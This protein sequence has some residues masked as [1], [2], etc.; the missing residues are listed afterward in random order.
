ME[1]VDR[2]MMVSTPKGSAAVPGSPGLSPVRW[3]RRYEG[4][5]DRFVFMSGAV[6][7]G[8]E[9]IEEEVPEEPSPITSAKWKK[10]NAKVF[11]YV[12]DCCMTEKINMETEVGYEVADEKRRIKHA[13]QS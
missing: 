2:M 6:N 7:V 9:W 8:T 1:E 4:E 10:E 13:V 11:K 3:G 5:G 12:D